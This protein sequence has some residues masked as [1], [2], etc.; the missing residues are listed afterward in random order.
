MQQ[1][2]ESF[3]AYFG[4]SSRIAFENME[5]INEPEEATIVFFV[6]RKSQGH[7]HLPYPKGGAGSDSTNFATLGANTAPLSGN[8]KGWEFRGYEVR[9]WDVIMGRSL[10][11]NIAFGAGGRARPGGRQ[12]PPATQARLSEF[13][14]RTPLRLP[15]GTG[16]RLVF[17]ID[18]T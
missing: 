7:S 2:T 4:S 14:L 3:E 1:I 13:C 8:K 5:E 16:G 11:D 18:D 10:A 9:I 17:A 12:A 15:D 6:M